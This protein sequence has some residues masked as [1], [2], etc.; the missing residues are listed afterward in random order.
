MKDFQNSV[1]KNQRWFEKCFCP[2]LNEEK[3][4]FRKR[5]SDYSSKVPAV[6]N[7]KNK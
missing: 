2:K 5:F 7:L 6:G 3:S 1:L 4:A